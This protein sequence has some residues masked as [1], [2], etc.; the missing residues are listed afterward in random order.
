[1]GFILWFMM[2]TIINTAE[3]AFLA[4]CMINVCVSFSS[5]IGEALIVEIS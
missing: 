3:K 5:V 4:L 2:G 1:L